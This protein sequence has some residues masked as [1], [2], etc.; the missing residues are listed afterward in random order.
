MKKSIGLWLL[1]LLTGATVYG[2]YAI[3][4][5]FIKAYNSN[6]EVNKVHAIAYLFAADVNPPETVEICWGDGTCSEVPMTGDIFVASYEA[7][8]TYAGPGNYRISVN[9]CCYANLPFMPATQEFSLYTTRVVAEP[10]VLYLNSTPTLFQAV[11]QLLFV[12][13]SLHFNFNA[14]DADGDSISYHLVV[15]PGLENYLYPNE[16]FPGP[17]DI[18]TLDAETGDL[19]WDAP[20][21]TGDYYLAMNIISYRNSQPIDTMVTIM[22]IHVIEFPVGTSSAQVDDDWRWYPNPASDVLV[23]S[24]REGNISGLLEVVDLAGRVVI[25]KDLPK[26]PLPFSLEI[27]HLSAGVYILRL[28]G[29]ALGQFVKT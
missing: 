19:V 12:D 20:H 9:V 24:R 5:G 14:L 13:Q 26:S 22:Q 21:A 29:R 23:V 8:H 4:A 3:G 15:P 10:G 18:L 28:Q 25:R 11:T 6:I 7:I 16:I 2:Q 27:K 1:A 17:N